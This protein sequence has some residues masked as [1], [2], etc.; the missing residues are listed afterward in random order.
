MSARPLAILAI[1]LAATAFTLLPVCDAIFDCGCTW[2]MWGAADHCNIHHPH[3]PHCPLCANWALGGLAA[4]TLF[5]TWTSALAIGLA[6][7]APRR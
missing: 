2:P 5:V 7:V 1:A 4:A 3:P 6:I